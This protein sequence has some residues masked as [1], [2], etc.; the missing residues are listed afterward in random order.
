MA[1]GLLG[2]KVVNSRDVE[3][4]YTVPNA[5]T[6][7]FNVNVLNNGAA[8]ANVNVYVSDKSYQD[9]DFE[10]YNAESALWSVAGAFDAPLDIVGLGQNSVITSMSTAPQ[11]SAS[12]TDADALRLPKVITTDQ[13]A[14]TYATTNAVIA[15]NPLTFYSGTTIYARAMTTGSVYTLAN[16]ISNGAAAV[17]A[18]NWGQAAATDNVVYATNQGGP[19]AMFYLEGA[20]GGAITVNSITDYRN[21]ATATYGTAFSWNAGQI[22]KIL[23]VKTAEERFVTGTA[24]GIMYVSTTGA[25]TTNT[26]MTSGGTL[27]APGGAAGNLIGGCAIESAT[28]NEGTLYLALTSNKVIYASY[29]AATP[30]STTTADYSIFDFPAGVTTD[31][32]SDIRAEGDNFVI[33]TK[34]GEKIS[35]D[36]L[37][38]TWVTS[39]HYPT[40]PYAIT[41][42]DGYK[43]DGVLGAEL[44]LVRGRTYRFHVSDSSNNTHPLLF[45][46]TKDGVHGGGT[47]FDTGVV[48]KMGNPTA[49]GDFAVEHTASASYL[50]DYAT[51]NGEP[52]VIEITVPAGAPGVLYTYCNTHAG[53]GFS[54]QVI[55]EPTDAPHDT[56]TLFAT[57]TIWNADNGDAIKKYDVFFDGATF[58]REERFFDLPA[59]DLFDTAT[60]AAGEILERTGIMASAGEQVIVTTDAD[61]VI[62]RVHGIEE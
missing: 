20:S 39:K 44:Q 36:D 29:T 1:N 17:S 4:V 6:A 12:S 53:L 22:T 35:T 15:G 37:G 38:L 32:V 58:S 34:L 55:D 28:P 59:L 51:Y 25:P 26:M 23:G 11:T 16:Y 54:I 10:D 50:S 9:I 33:I 60:I 62:V 48:Y 56:K 47:A 40:L 3:L 45:S 49:T 52:K 14:G 30:L 24:T 7:T 8:S 21:A 2:K 19:H 46:A 13:G 43:V 57:S 18:S 27:F 5:R 41:Q 42:A 31:D 61:N